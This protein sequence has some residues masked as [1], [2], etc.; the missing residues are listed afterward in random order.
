MTLENWEYVPIG[1]DPPD[2]YSG[3][4]YSEKLSS[5]DV[6]QN[7]ITRTYFV[8]YDVLPSFMDDLLGYA[9]TSGSGIKRVLPNFDPLWANMWAMEASAK[10]LGKLTQGTTA[11]GKVPKYTVAEITAVYRSPAFQIINDDDIDNELDRYVIREYGFGGEFITINSTGMKFVSNIGADGKHLALNQPPA[12]P[13]MTM[14]L[15]YT[16]EM[17]PPNFAISPYVPP[18]LTP[19]VN[20]YGKINSTAFDV[21]HM[22]CPAGTVLFL[23][24][25][26]KMT[27]YRLTTGAETTNIFWRIA[28]KFVYRNNGFISRPNTGGGTLNEWAGHQFIW[29]QSKQWWDLITVDGTTSGGRLFQTA[30][31]NTLFT[32]G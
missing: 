29:D 24:I 27:N 14:D 1:S 4:Q 20:C 12:R 13:T 28:M 32:I 8:S 30:N 7:Q 10:G 31:L 25:D 6:A 16:W 9:E 5:P 18:N 23:G 26:P 21:N 2:L 11:D 15:T 17:V 22:N 3:L 19:L